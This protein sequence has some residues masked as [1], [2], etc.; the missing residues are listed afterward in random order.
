LESARK[1]RELDPAVRFGE[2]AMKGLGQ[3]V[4]G[5]ER[6]RGVILGRIGGEKGRG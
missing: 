2:M 6:R 5:A 1:K 4:R 3:L